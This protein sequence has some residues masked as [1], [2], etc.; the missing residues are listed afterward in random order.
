MPIAAGH[1]P[2]T[3][4]FLVQ[5][6]MILDSWAEPNKNL[7]TCAEFQNKNFQTKIEI[8]PEIAIRFVERIHFQKGLSPQSQQFVKMRA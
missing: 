5:F 1:F 6:H 7:S 8:F 4:T 2:R 3:Q